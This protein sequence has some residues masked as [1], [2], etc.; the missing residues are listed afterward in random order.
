MKKRLLFL[1]TWLLITIFTVSLFAQNKNVTGQ[2]TERNNL[3]VPYATITL[4]NSSQAIVSDANGNFTLSIPQNSVL[5]ISASGY[6]TETIKAENSTDLRITLTEDVARL[7][8]IVVTGLTTSVKRRNLS[9][10]VATI[11]SKELNGISPAQTF[12]AALE[13][14]CTPQC[15][16]HGG[17]V[18]RSPR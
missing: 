8:E 7:D 6:K 3:P 18:L 9:N 17:R 12:D 13:V 1:I 15:K 11:T 16:S 10:A 4:K 14:R 2:V 5:I